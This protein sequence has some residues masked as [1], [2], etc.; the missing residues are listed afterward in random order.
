M[1]HKD[2]TSYNKIGIPNGYWEK[3]YPHSD[4]LFFT[5]YYINFEEYGYEEIYDSNVKLRSKIYYAR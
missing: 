3:Y 4:R 2:I 1:Q 5:C